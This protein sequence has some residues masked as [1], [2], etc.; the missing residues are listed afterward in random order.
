MLAITRKPIAAEAAEPLARHARSVCAHVR[1]AR[2]DRGYLGL[3][4]VE[5]L[6]SHRRQLDE[7]G[8]RFEDIEH[9]TFGKDGFDDAVDQVGSIEQS[10]GI[11][12]AQLTAPRPPAT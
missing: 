6:R 10:L 9:K 1:G 8:E 2:R 12:L 4:C 3:S 7:A 5:E 11:E